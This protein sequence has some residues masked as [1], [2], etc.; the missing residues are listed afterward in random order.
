[1]MRFLARLFI[2]LTLFSILY[3]L[4]TREARAEGE[5]ETDYDV[6]YQIEQAGRTNV[7]QDIKLKNKTAN[8]YADRFEL[9]IGSTKVENVQARDASG[10]MEVKVKFEDNVT[11]ISVKFNQRVIG[12]DKELPWTLTYTSGELTSRAGQIWEVSIPRIA[13]AAEISKYDV[14]VQ[15]PS[16]FGPIAFTVPSP[17]TSTSTRNLAEFTF[18]KDQLTQTGIAMSFGEKQVFSFI[19][20]YYLENNNL[21]SSIQDLALPPD[22]NYQ[23][24]VLDKIDPAPVNVSVDTDGNFLAHFKLAPKQQLDVKVTGTVEVFSKPFRNIYPKLSQKEKDLYTQPQ[25]YWETD[26][27]FIREKAAELKTPQK[28]YEFVTNFLSYSQDRLNQPEIERK[29]AAAAILDPQDAVCMEFTDLFIAVARSAGI[30][31]REVEGY[32]YTQNERLRPLSLA[33]NGGDILHAW[34]EYWDD[35]LGW[36]QIDPTW[37]S[38]SGGLDYF[39]KLDFNHITFVQRGAFSTSPYPAGAYKRTD[40]Q[41]T[42]MVFVSFAE[43]LPNPTP[44]VNLRLEVADTVIS[45]IPL[46]IRTQIK[47]A[48]NTS[49]FENVL[50]LEADKFQLTSPKVQNLGLLPPY[51]T[52][53][54]EYRLQTKGYLTKTTSNLILYLNDQKVEKTV[55]IIPIY[56]L[57]ITPSFVAGLALAVAIIT[58]G[59]ILYKK[60]R[61]VKVPQG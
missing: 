20:D 39:N 36:V 37:G 54:V 42:R 12:L 55:A 28:I 9:K 60:F 26:N 2:F 27:G 1:M 48:G 45:G 46:K 22:N 57:F 8:Y 6:T 19:L 13:T 41:D 49:L 56:Y 38:T 11:S 58:G 52:R 43:E 53:V 35:N 18:N 21:T 17:L 50:T 24:V 23:K 33:L 5:F 61:K 15:V 25:K 10:P 4:H 7:A 47:N 29:G 14:K 32:A 59:F 44:N 40:N 30:P 3:S 16:S 31:T 34:P 51:S